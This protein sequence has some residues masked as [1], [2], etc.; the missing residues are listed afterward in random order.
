MKLNS[1]KFKFLVYVGL[2]I[3][4]VS[5]GIGVTSYINSSSAIMEEIE[6]NLPDK[7]NDIAMLVRSRLDTRESELEAISN[8]QVIKS[9]DWDE[10]RPILEEEIARTDFATI[11]LVDLAGQ[12]SYVDSDALD[13]SDRNYVQEALAGNTNVSEML[14]SRAINA[15]VAMVATPIEA[16]GEIV[17]ALIARMLGEDVIE[18][19][20]DVQLGQDGYAYMLDNTG[21]VVADRNID[22]VMEQFNPM[23]EVSQDSSL[24]SMADTFREMIANGSGFSRYHTL[25]N[26]ESFIGYDEVEGTNWLVGVTVPVEQAL[27]NLYD[28]RNAIVFVTLPIFIIALIL[29]YI[30]AGKLTKPIN[31]L[32]GLI[33]KLSNF[34]L[35]NDQKNNVNKYLDRDDEIGEITNAVVA[36]QK[37]LSDIIDQIMNVS[38]NLAASSQELSA[39]SE[40]MKAS[41]E[42]V[43]T[44]TEEVASGAEEQTA[45]IEETSS[46]IDELDQGLDNINQLSENMNNQSGKVLENIK[47]GNQSIEKSIDQINRVKLQAEKTSKNVNELGER[48][49]KIGEIVELI[50]GISSQTNL[51]ALNAAIEAARAGE[52][53]RGFSVVA[54]EIRQL[55]EESSNATQEITGLIKEIQNGAKAS[56]EEMNKAQEAVGDSVEA[57]GVTDQSFKVIQEAVNSLEDLINNLDNSAERISENSAMVNRSIQ[58]IGSVSEQSAANAEEVVA[59]TEEQASSTQ[60]IVH[61]SE[62]LAEMAEK[63]SRTVDQFKI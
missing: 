25:D 27:T 7:A 56:V 5:L 28:T 52:A 63:L 18:I 15:P 42:E 53:G 49:Q 51:L 36:M 50:E 33:T 41:A 43:A 24:E 22:L 2:I 32:T 9:M 8:G 14:I 16:E 21:V 59:S 45:Q 23:E 57:I 48:S 58:E 34:D 30:V 38:N 31:E 29:M 55:A 60:E 6:A 17:G 37:N 47:S 44:A 1:L 61:A 13:L 20:S 62:D 4:V 40:E 35:R 19:V 39:S 12:A 54:D 3:V 11:A 26:V 46:N 10:I